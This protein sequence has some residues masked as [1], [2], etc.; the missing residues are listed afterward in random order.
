[1]DRTVGIED[2]AGV[3][4]RVSWGAI[5]GGSVIALSVY[6]LLGLFFAGVGLSLNRAGVEA[7]NAAIVSIVAGVLSIVVALWCGGC[8]TSILTAGETRREAIIHGVLTWA[9][10]TGFTLAMVGMGLRTGYNALLGAALVGQSTEA[11]NRS[12]EQVARDNGIP[13]ERIDQLK[14]DLNLQNAQAQANNPENRNEVSKGA[15]IATWSV[16]AGTLLSIGAAVLGGLSGM[17]PTFRL[18]PGVVATAER[19]EV[20]VTR[21]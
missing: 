13:Q 14:R 12:W 19:R 2:V 5:F 1:M 11:A 6:L 8:V 20:T 18:F 21:T 10:V 7:G 4:S 9:V 15:M 17:G 16:F 3:Q